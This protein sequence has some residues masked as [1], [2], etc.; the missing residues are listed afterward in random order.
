MRT[1]AVRASD[2]EREAVAARLREAAAE[3]RVEPDEL[4]E[5]LQRAFGARTRSD[6]AVLTEDLPEPGAVARRPASFLA[7]G[8][9]R[10][11]AVYAVV[12]VLLVCLWMA[13]V[14]ARD[15]LLVGNSEFAWPIFS[16]VGWATAIALSARRGQRVVE[17]RR[18]RPGG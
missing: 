8:R 9:W 2:R 17:G 4:E 6:L 3:G 16:I 18:L 5:R 11:W 13:D 12:N 7:R 14:G 15:P 1:V 10:Q